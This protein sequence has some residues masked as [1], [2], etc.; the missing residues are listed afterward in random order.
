ML[1]GDLSV[2]EGRNRLTSECTK[3]VRMFLRPVQAS[4]LEKEKKV[5]LPLEK[6]SRQFRK[7]GGFQMISQ[8]ESPFPGGRFLPFQRRG[9]FP[10]VFKENQRKTQRKKLSRESPGEPGR[11]RRELG[12]SFFVEK[13]FSGKI[14]FSPEENIFARKKMF[15]VKKH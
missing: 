12:S 6:L 4:F 9:W 13:H 11:A 5:Q 8:G 1:F 3:V 14:F 10:G 2:I 15:S 7:S